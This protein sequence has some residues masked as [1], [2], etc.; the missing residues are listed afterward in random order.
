MTEEYRA[1]MDNH[2]WDLVP[3]PPDANI[4]RCIWLFRHKFNEND[5]LQRYKAWLV[6]NGKCQQV[7]IDCDE[8]FSPVVKPTTIRT[9]LSLAVSGASQFTNSTFATYITTCGFRSTV[10]DTSLFVYKKGHDMAYLLLYVDDIV[11][12]ASNDQFLTNIIALLS[13][14]FAMLD[15]GTLH[16]FLGIQVKH[17]DGGMFLS[18][19]NYAANILSRAHME[20]CK[21]SST[22]V[23]TSPKM[24]ATSGELL[25]DGTHYRQLAGALQYLTITRPDLTYAVQQICLFMHAPRDPHFQFL[26]RVLRYLKGTITYGLRDNLVSW[27]SKRQAT[28][29][30]SSAEAEYRGDANAVAETSWL[31]NL[32]LKLYV[33]TRKATVVYCDN[34]SAVYLSENPVQHQRTKHVELDIHFVREKVRIGAVRVLHVPADFQYADIFT[35]GLPRHLFNRFRSSLCIRPSIAQTEGVY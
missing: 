26:K 14:E 27:S 12:T 28:I 29:S 24:S 3:R 11:L 34:I 10:S 4:I 21:P 15:L 13:R 1:L 16:H 30:R 8:T 18:Q 20:D 6:V 22:P 19:E 9:V 32:L 2:T 17:K 35:K 25:P 23:D 5:T 33:P 7:G 31:R